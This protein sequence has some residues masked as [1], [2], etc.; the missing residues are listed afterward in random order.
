M[1][2][3]SWRDWLFSAKTFL[4]AMLALYIALAFSLPRPYW[5]M[6]AVYVVANPL[7]GATVSKAID[8]LLGTLLGATG[9]VILMT[10]F[11]D[12]P[13]ILML[14]VALW[15]G[16][17]LFV[18]LHGRTP[19]NY[20]FMLA[21][22]TLP[23]IVLP[24]VEVPETIFDVALARSEEIML[25]IIVTAAVGTLILPMSVRPVLEG[26][27]Q[28]WLKDAAAWAGEV[29]LSKG[30]DPATP[31]ARQRLAADITPLNA[32]ISQLPHDPETR[33][34]KRHAEALR[35]RL[36]L[37]LPL[38]SA[39]ADRMHALRLELGSFPA[40]LEALAGQIAAWIAAPSPEPDEKAPERLRAALQALHAPAEGG[41]WSRLVWSSLVSRLSELIDLWQDC[42]VLRRHI[43]H[44][45]AARSWRPVLRHRPVVRQEP[46]HDR[47]LMA[48]V[49]GSTV[50]A[51]FL[52]GLLWIWSGW[53]GGG[54]AVAF[55]AIACCFFGGLDRPAPMMK[56]MLTWS[57]IAY[58]FAGFYLFA[59][60]PQIS[61]FEMIVLALAPPFLLVGA[62]IPRPELA[63]ITLLLAVNIAGDLGLQ[64]RWSG[65]I[66][67]YIE[68]GLAIAVGLIF[69]ILWTLITRPFGA[70]L[71]AR[72]LVRAGWTD[73]AELA[74]GSR[75]PDHAAL[76]G[77]T[78]DRL[79]QLMPRLASDGTASLASI[80]G[81]AE[82]RSGYNIIALQ[83]DRRALPAEARARLDATLRGTAR[84][85]AGCAEK[86]E[87]LAAPESLRRA[88]DGTLR[89]VLTSAPGQAQ[90][91]SVDALVGLRRALF[92]QAPGP[93]GGEPGQ[94]GG[95]AAMR[96]PL[97]A[98]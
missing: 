25:G 52:A 98:E 46:H 16:V 96:A 8:R 61:D 6:T 17:F 73:L 45:S 85:F 35:G 27:I 74:E 79:A 36:L 21:G 32:L 2:W 42:L 47:G 62:L 86:G 87:R 39:I 81:L 57:L 9:A 22:Y 83:R 1:R 24:S 58:A 95:E 77:R 48:F 15:A 12:A 55:V 84:F 30:A 40:E 11:I 66:A 41:L 23:L 91:S 56:M 82:L 51:T 94:A 43:A 4:A 29:L 10:L 38:L 28:S 71:A 5:A 26:R 88:I 59:I 44:G 3:P 65:D 13:E 90:Q 20:V 80:D 75:A 70:E 7:S 76:I 68:G 67:S 19:R 97:A 49:V 54:S 31:L 69:A 60:L 37:L 78:L 34:L 33:D 53:A 14:A 92:P 89:A 64:G 93:G 50:L 63:L 18:A 72:R